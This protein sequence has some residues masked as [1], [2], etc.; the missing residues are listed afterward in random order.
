MGINMEKCKLCN[1]EITLSKCYCG[2]ADQK[3]KAEIRL[4]FTGTNKKKVSERLYKAYKNINEW[5]KPLFSSASFDSSP[6]LNKHEEDVKNKI[7]D[8]FVT[9][10]MTYNYQDDQI[11][12][13]IAEL[14]EMVKQEA[15]EVCKRIQADLEYDRLRE[16]NIFKKDGKHFM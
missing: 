8:G 11:D 3:Y 7:I 2:L 15:S 4:E 9:L 13:F 6:K 1:N 12:G 14:P 5:K 10:I 16:E